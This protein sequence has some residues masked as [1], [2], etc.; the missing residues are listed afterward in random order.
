MN[1]ARYHVPSP[2]FVSTEKF[3]R[4][5]AD[6]YQLKRSLGVFERTM[7]GIGAIIGT[8]IF[9]LTVKAAAGTFRA[10]GAGGSVTI[11]WLVGGFS[12]ALAALF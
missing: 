2:G 8:G 1:P 4:A 9:V 5:Q 7:M 11:T 6:A 10:L 12:C 3:L